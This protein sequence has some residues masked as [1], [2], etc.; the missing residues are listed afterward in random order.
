MYDVT[1]DTARQL[2]KV[3]VSGFW[4]EETFKTYAAEATKRSEELRRTGGFKYVLIDMSDFP[5]QSAVV[6][7]MHGRLLQAAQDGYGVR[8]AVVMT[9]ALSRLQATRVAKLTGND[10]FDDADTA[11]AALMQSDR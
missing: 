2:M 3:K 11:V 9:S 8:A 6:A 7:E 10:L 1:I 5:I 4:S